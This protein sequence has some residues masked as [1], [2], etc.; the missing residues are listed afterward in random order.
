MDRSNSGS[1]QNFEK[2]F[3]NISHMENGFNVPNVI[4]C[5][6]LILTDFIL[7]LKNKI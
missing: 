7:D 1:S 2:K 3:K 4:F 5:K 6:S